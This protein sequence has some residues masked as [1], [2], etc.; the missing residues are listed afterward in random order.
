MQDQF[1]KLAEKDKVI[2]SLTEKTKEEIKG[3]KQE[4][5]L[6][7][8]NPESKAILSLTEKTKTEVSSIKKQIKSI[9]EKFVRGEKGDVGPKGSTGPKG[10]IGS[11]GPK[12]DKGDKGTDGITG[13][14]G[15][16]GIKGDKGDQ[17]EKGETG[18]K[19]DQGEKG[20]I[21]EIGSQ[22]IQGEKGDQGEKGEIGSQGIQGEKGIDGKQGSKGE[23][24][25]QGIQ[26][27]KG[28][29]GD[30]GDTGLKGDKGETGLQGIQG[31][32]GD[33]GDKGDKGEIGSQGIKGE[34]GDKG[35]KGEKGEK[36][37]S[38]SIEPIVEQFEQN[39]STHKREILNNLNKLKLSGSGSGSYWL[40]DLGDTDHN[41]VIAA[42]DGQALV[43]D[44]TIKKW[45]PGDIGYTGSL[46]YTG[47]Q[48]D[49][50]FT[51]SKGDIGFTGSLGFTGSKGDIGF[52]GSLGY[53]GSAGVGY[54]GSKGDLGYTGSA[55]VGYTGSSS[56]L[57]YGSFHSDNT[58]TLT[59]S[60]NSNTTDPLAVVSTTGFPSSGALLIGQE[61]LT[62]T[63]KDATNFTGIT[64][65]VSS[66]NSATHSN[67]SYVSVAQVTTAG[68]AATAY[69]DA[70][71]LSNGVILN[72]STSEITITNAGT[73][74]IMFSA[75]TANA[76]NAPDDIVIWF[77]VDG[78]HI[79][80][81]ASYVTIP[82]IHANV[83]GSA[84]CAANIFNTFTAGQ[85]L[86]LEW[87][88]I[89]GSGILTT[90][91]QVNNTIPAS[92]AII[93]TVNKIS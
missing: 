1:D 39:L 27:Q 28:D 22:G 16:P 80:S 33:K 48:G 70:T 81:S 35:E 17:G 72:S 67:G 38:A 87:T 50:G 84:I 40:N 11:I 41:R 12:G 30:K 83:T 47:S 75:Q 91:P 82:S 13:K 25:L 71:D 32:K 44:A 14:D 3:L 5:T 58:T 29:K 56:N 60:I 21:G 93:L 42:T 6:L 62:Y 18:L 31:Q 68:V 2:L 92:P 59:A 26:G 34:K 88:S 65:G 85:K 89:G 15:K 52:T 64:R 46:G 69:I 53:T 63:G 57:Y 43:Y 51:G 45:V 20:E 61:V 79:P 55:G 76:S 19:G 78:N 66:S 49:L 77:V 7:K 24:G 8:N 10:D 37:D 54:T 74:N 23:T 73:Y 4:L 90:Y 9:E 36:G 86:T